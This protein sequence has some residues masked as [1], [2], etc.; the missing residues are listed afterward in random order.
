MVCQSAE[1]ADSKE[2]SEE[3]ARLNVI[4][5]HYDYAQGICSSWEVV[6]TVASTTASC[7]VMHALMPSQFVPII[8]GHGSASC[9]FGTH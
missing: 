7:T 1:M 9:T 4:N 2:D 5:G 6:V 8:H 3:Q